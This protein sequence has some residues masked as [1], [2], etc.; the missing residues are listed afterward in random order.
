MDYVV[1]HSDTW[2]RDEWFD[3]FFRAH[4]GSL[5][6]MG[7]MVFADVR[8]MTEDKLR[9]MRAFGIDNFLY[10]VESGSEGILKGNGKYSS[11]GR[12]KDVVGK[13]VDAG[14]GVSASFVLGLLGETRE[15]IAETEGL[16]NHFNEMGGVRAYANVIIPLPGSRLWGE[17]M[18][19]P[20]AREK[21]GNIGLDYNLE[22]VRSD[23]LSSCTNVGLEDVVAARDRINSNSGLGDHEYAR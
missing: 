20:V 22:E 12:I 15:T 13:T 5:E 18:K 14:I 6:D 2:A 11:V 21:Y 1:D 16:I 8:D 9:K 4:R 10:G 17:F 3:A 19:D 23:F 7:M